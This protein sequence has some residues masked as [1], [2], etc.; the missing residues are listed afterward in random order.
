MCYDTEFWQWVCAGP[1]YVECDGWL[2]GAYLVPCNDSWVLVLKVPG[3]GASTAVMTLEEL[4]AFR[5]KTVRKYRH[6]RW[7]TREYECWG[8]R[9]L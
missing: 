4:A 6:S 2:K 7:S 3:F 8:Y 1:G 5:I 9:A